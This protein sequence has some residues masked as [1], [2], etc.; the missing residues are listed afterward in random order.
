MSL[1]VLMGISGAGKDYY[2][3]NSLPEHTLA[4]ADSFFMRN[5]RYHFDP[6]WLPAAH[7]ACFRKVIEAIQR[8]DGLVVVSNTNTRVTELAPYMALAQAYEIEAEI[9][10][11]RI[12]PK[13]AAMRNQHEVPLSQV[14]KQ[15]EQLEASLNRML[16]WW[17]YA[18]LTW[19]VAQGRYQ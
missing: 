2:A 14:R 3:K 1:I 6:H 9:R 11:L 16:P 15:H 5:G 19:D 4:S 12:D 17:K 18:V 10:V 13:I 8:R 7:G